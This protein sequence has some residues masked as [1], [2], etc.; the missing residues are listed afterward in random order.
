MLNEI[1]G[2]FGGIDAGRLRMKFRI[3]QAEI[4]DA[5]DNGEFFPIV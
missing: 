4:L 2:L 1:G 5:F 3:Q